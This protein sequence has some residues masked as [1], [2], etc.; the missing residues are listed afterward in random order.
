MQAE[1]LRGLRQFVQVVVQVV[2]QFRHETAHVGGDAF[3]VPAHVLVDAFLPHL[4]HQIGGDFLAHGTFVLAHPGVQQV[5]D[6]VQRQMQAGGGKRRRLVGDGDGAAAALGLQ[7]FADVVDDVGIDH[8]HVADGG[9]RVIRHRQAA[10]LARQPFLRAVRAV[11]HDGVGLELFAHPQVMRHV[12]VRGGGHR[13]MVERL[14]LVLPAL[15]ARGLWRQDELADAV[16][17]NDEIRFA[18]V[19]HHH[20]RFFRIAPAFLHVGLRRRRLPG[21]PGAVGLDRQALGQA[22][23]QQRFEFAVAVV[24]GEQALQVGD[25][26]LL[27]FRRHVVTGLTQR[28]ERGFHA[29]RHVEVGGGKILFARRVVPE[30]HRHLLLGVGQ[31]LQADQ[32]ER[33]VDHGGGLLRQHLD[34]ALAAD[35]VA[36]HRI[37]N[38][39]VL[40]LREI[41]RHVHQWHALGV[42]APGGFVATAIGER[43]RHRDAERC[44]FLVPA[45]RVEDDLRVDERVGH[46]LA[47]DGQHRRVRR[48]H[49]GVVGQG[50]PAAGF[51]AG[52]QV[53]DEGGLFR[54]DVNLVE[55]N[56][57]RWRA[58][59]GVDAAPAEIL[60]G[61]GEYLVRRLRVIDGVVRENKGIGDFRRRLAAQFSGQR[62]EKALEIG[63]APVG[64]VGMQ[65]PGEQRAETFGLR[66]LVVHPDMAALETGER[67][68]Q[69]ALDGV[70]HVGAPGVEDH[71][72]AFIQQGIG[73]IRRNPLGKMRFHRQ[74]VL[75]G[76]FLH[77]LELAGRNR[78]DGDEKY[79]LGG[80]AAGADKE[81]GGETGNEE[82]A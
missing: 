45:F 52:N 21:Q 33:L 20:G 6:F 78:G 72:I 61:R 40:G 13:G 25:E 55:G 4:L 15:A 5:M 27:G 34:V 56:R 18:A 50:Q 75:G 70:A 30:Q 71:R 57:H 29:A 82:G 35:D 64:V 62:G 79:V 48:H 47:I 81:Q 16:A 44:Q 53:V 60:G 26:R 41:K 67:L 76:D 17:R 66:P 74:A 36:H 8:R 63:P 77:H 11:V 58:F 73:Q 1:R 54:A 24:G 3:V 42:G 68:F 43:L 2:V 31:A 80:G 22:V 49:P 37:E 28:L 9:K 10:F 19:F 23:A 7:G 51:D 32:L 39:G 38:A 69:P 46:R 14:F 65:A 59:G 12:V